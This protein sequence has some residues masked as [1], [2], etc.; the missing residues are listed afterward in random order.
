MVRWLK[1]IARCTSIK[2]DFIKTGA[3]ALKGQF[4]NGLLQGTWYIY[5]QNGMLAKKMVYHNGVVTKVLRYRVYKE[6][7][8]EKQ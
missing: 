4:I 7:R 1:R 2:S 3:V 5:S 8:K 6:D